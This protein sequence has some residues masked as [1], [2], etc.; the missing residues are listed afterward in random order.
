[1]LT[2]I[3]VVMHSYGRRSKGLY[4]E[5]LLFSVKAGV[6]FEV[7]C[8]W[9]FFFGKKGNNLCS[10]LMGYSLQW[11]FSK[12]F[13]SRVEWIIIKPKTKSTINA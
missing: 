2:L 8:R 4:A 3:F 12:Y 9:I 1:M 10:L 5:C 6:R 13:K 11:I 7:K